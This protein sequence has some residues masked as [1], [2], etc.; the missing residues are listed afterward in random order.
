MR[1][2]SSFRKANTTNKHILETNVDAQEHNYAFSI[3]SY[4][5]QSQYGKSRYGR[6]DPL[7]DQS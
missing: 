7:D 1:G 5:D 6:K 3:G 2:I 4:G